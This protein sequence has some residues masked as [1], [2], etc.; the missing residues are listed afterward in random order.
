MRGICRIVN[1]EVRV[2][3]VSRGVTFPS[4]SWGNAASRGPEARQPGPVV[5]LGNAIRNDTLVDSGRAKNRILH[6]GVSGH[7]LLQKAPAFCV[8][9]VSW[10]SSILPGPSKGAVGSTG[11]SVTC[12]DGGAEAGMLHSRIAEPSAQLA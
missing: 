9:K 5:N 11:A 3:W 10:K 8:E 6:V 1:P 12:L 2:L 7:I 4:S